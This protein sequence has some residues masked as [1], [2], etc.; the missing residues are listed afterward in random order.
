MLVCY[1]NL[2]KGADVPEGQCNVGIINTT[3]GHID[4][5][6]PSVFAHL[7]TDPFAVQLTTDRIVVA[8]THGN[9]SSTGSGRAVAGTIT[10]ETIAWGPVNTFNSL[11]NDQSTMIRHDN[12]AAVVCFSQG[13]N[14]NIVQCRAAV[15]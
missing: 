12:D 13:S 6:P 2:A 10:N 7:G 9:D 5:G 3:D 8:Y 15:R 4:F 1:A 11:H 14:N